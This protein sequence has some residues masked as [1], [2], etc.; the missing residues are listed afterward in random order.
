[1]RVQ[2]LYADSFEFKFGDDAVITHCADRPV[3]PIR[4]NFIPIE[5]IVV[6]LPV[7]QQIRLPWGCLIDL[8]GIVSR[9]QPVTPRKYSTVGSRK[10]CEEQF[11]DARDVTLIDDKNSEV[12]LELSGALLHAVTSD[13][14]GRVLGMKAQPSFSGLHPFQSSR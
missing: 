14:L 6:A 1:M 5:N 13:D 7:E 3:P 4:Y 8:I 11:I 9:V 2:K 12:V 10:D